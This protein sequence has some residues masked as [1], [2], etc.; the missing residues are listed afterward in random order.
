MMVVNGWQYDTDELMSVVKAIKA[1]ESIK[2]PISAS[3]IDQIR[4]GFSPFEGYVQVSFRSGI[5]AKDI[6]FYPEY[7]AGASNEHM[8]NELVEA[9]LD[10]VNGARDSVQVGEQ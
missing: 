9:C 2:Q 6:L 3:G 7:V 1:R 5:W 10:F 8:L 4:V